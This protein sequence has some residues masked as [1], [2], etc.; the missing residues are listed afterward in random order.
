MTS[1]LKAR[2][3]AGEFLLGTFLKT[4]SPILVEV[5]ATYPSTPAIAIEPSASTPS[6]RRSTG[7]RS[8]RACSRRAHAG[9]R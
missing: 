5:L 9:Y 6:T 8:T 3:A 4:P 1:T 2:L 7:R